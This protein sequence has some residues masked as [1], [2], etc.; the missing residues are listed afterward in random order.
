MVLPAYV[1]AAGV[2]VI[3]LFGNLVTVLL[4]LGRKIISFDLRGTIS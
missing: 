2:C 3:P 1:A 4:F